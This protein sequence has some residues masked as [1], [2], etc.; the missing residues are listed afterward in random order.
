M[1]ALLGL[2]AAVGTG[3]IDEAHDGSVEAFGLVHEA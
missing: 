1:A 3:G 2:D